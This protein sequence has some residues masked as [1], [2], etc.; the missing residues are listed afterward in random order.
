MRASILATLLLLVV[1]G[2]AE[3][4]EIIVEVRAE[5]EVSSLTLSYVRGAD[6]DSIDVDLSAY[7]LPVTQ[8]LRYEGGSRDVTI[9]VSATTPAGPVTLERVASFVDGESR[10][11]VFLI[12]GDMSCAGMCTDSQT[13]VDGECRDASECPSE[14]SCGTCPSGCTCTFEATE[15]NECAIRC[16]EGSTCDI[17]CEASGCDILI[18]GGATATQIKCEDSACN[19][20]VRGT[21]EA[22]ETDGRPGSAYQVFDQGRVEWLECRRGTSCDGQTNDSSYARVKC[23]TCIWDGFDRSEVGVECPC[24]N[25]LG[26]CGIRQCDPNDAT[27]CGDGQRICGADCSAW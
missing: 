12:G 1:A 18:E 8:G 26:V 4:T 3:A 24:D 16:A 17:T 15:E 27:R 20:E 6:T 7:P 14:L 19:V 9:E 25:C 2:C 21:V 11:E 10:R 22:A 13:C 5:T 23:A